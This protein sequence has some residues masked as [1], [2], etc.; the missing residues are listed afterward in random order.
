MS[1]KPIISASLS[2]LRTV[3]CAR[4]QQ[5]VGQDNMRPDSVHRYRCKR[6]GDWIM[7]YVVAPA[8]AAPD[9]P[10]PVLTEA[11]A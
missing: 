9:E 8:A 7:V 10:A 4:C 2:D 3:H 6:C 5:P 1:A 11:A